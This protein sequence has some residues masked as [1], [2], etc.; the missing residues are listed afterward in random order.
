MRIVN[1]KGL[2]LN[3][4]SFS[5]VSDLRSRPKISSKYDDFIQYYFILFLIEV[6][7]SS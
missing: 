1:F 2:Q 3:F 5:L 4:Q 7:L 6:G